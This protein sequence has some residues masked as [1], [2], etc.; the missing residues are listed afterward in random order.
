[1]LLFGE[2]EIVDFMEVV[3][4]DVIYIVRWFVIK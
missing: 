3:D 2:S 4:L 1:M